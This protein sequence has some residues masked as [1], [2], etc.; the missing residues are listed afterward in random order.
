MNVKQLKSIIEDLP[1]DMIVVTP[2]SDHTYNEAG[3]V[4]DTAQ[5][6]RG[7]YSEYHDDYG[8]DEPGATL[9]EVLVII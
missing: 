7:L 1:D 4:P 3:A 6:H 5:Y 8:I 9:Q 2:G